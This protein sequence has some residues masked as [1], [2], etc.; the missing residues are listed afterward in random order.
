MTIPTPWLFA[1]LALVFGAF[2][3]R[4]YARHGRGLSPAGR[5]WRLVA[6]IFA[7]VAAVIW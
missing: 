1:A 6:V 2:A 3:L 7:V 5:T 4:E